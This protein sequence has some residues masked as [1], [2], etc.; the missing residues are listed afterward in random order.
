MRSTTSQRG[1]GQRGHTRAARPPPP[2]LLHSAAEGSS[3]AEG[4]RRALGGL[5]V[6]GPSTQPLKNDVATRSPTRHAFTRSP[7][8]RFR[9]HHPTENERV[10]RAPRVPPRRDHEPV[11]GVP[12]SAQGSWNASRQRPTAQRQPVSFAGQ[13]QN[14]VGGPASIAQ[15]QFRS[16]TGQAHP[17]GGLGSTPQTQ[18]G[19]LLGQKQ[20]GGGAASITHVQSRSLT[21]HAQIGGRG[22]GGRTGGPAS[23]L[24]QVQSAPVH[25]QTMGG[26]GGAASLP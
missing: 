11:R 26:G 22:P 24:P 21:G 1:G 20:I 5:G 16:S 23:V 25:V 13:L 6:C 7:R 12:V 17:T 18:S 8:P 15:T 4:C 14:G 10:L 3:A 2:A 9:R 19:S